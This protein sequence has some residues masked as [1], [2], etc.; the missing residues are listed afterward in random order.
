MYVAYTD[1]SYKSSKNSGGYAS[2]ILKDNKIICK[3][4]EG[5]TNTTNNR[6]ELLAVIETLKY[7]KNPVNITIVSDSKYVIDNIVLKNVDKW[8]ANNDLTKKNLDLWK[9]AYDLLQIHDV[10]FKWVKG[11]SDNELNQL[12][13]FFAQHAADCIELKNDLKTNEW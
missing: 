7:F 6:M 3:L 9:I 8:F 12:A 11:H 5:F 1:G 4:Y 10:N 2:I 13:D